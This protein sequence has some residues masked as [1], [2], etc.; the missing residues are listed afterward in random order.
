MA[1]IKPPFPRIERSR[2]LTRGIVGA[3]PFYEGSGPTAFD[4]SGNGNKGTLTGGPTWVGGNAGWALKF[5]ASQNTVDAG[6]PAILNGATAATWACWM[7]TSNVTTLAWIIHN[8]GAAASDQQFQI[9]L[10]SSGQIVIDIS[11]GGS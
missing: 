11:A 7:N 10:T 2:P 1:I 3:W 5:A 8:W 4:L 6:N 9:L